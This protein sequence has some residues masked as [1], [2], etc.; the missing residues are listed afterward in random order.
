MSKSKKELD[1][2]RAEFYKEFK[3]L[4]DFYVRGDYKIKGDLGDKNI[5][6]IKDGK[7]IFRLERIGRARLQPKYGLT[8][9][10]R[11]DEDFVVRLLNLPYI[12]ELYWR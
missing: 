10:T 3:R 4:L 11:S 2:Q 7:I 6:I 8:F 1:M 12:D 5:E 9:L